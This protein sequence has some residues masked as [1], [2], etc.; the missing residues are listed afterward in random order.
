MNKEL[1]KV[2][3]FAHIKIGLKNLAHLTGIILA[4]RA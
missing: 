1:V 3:P 2:R 4:T